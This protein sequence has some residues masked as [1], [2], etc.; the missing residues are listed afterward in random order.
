M[1]ASAQ[2]IMMSGRP[3][4]LGAAGPAQSVYLQNGHGQQP[5][6][7]TLV[8]AA[9]TVANTP[10]STAARPNSLVFIVAIPPEYATERPPGTQAA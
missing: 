6:A 9:A 7:A 10:N 4:T 2:C 3:S 5:D 8:A 1:S